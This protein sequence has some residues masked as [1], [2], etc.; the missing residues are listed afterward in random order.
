MQFSLQSATIFLLSAACSLAGSSP[1][2]VISEPRGELELAQALA[3][4][5]ARSPELE[6]YSWDVRIAEAAAMQAVAR[7][8]PELSFEVENALGGGAY[9]DFDS[10]EETLSLSQTIELGRK[11]MKRTAVARHEIAL[12]EHSFTLKRS[13]VLNG[14]TKAFLDVISAQQELAFAQTA[15]AMQNDLSEAQ[16]ALVEA[17]KIS[18]ADAESGKAALAFAEIA[19]TN[20]KAGLDLARSQLGAFWG[21]ATPHFTNAV[22][23]IATGTL[24]SR[25]SY[26]AGLADNPVLAYHAEAIRRH[27]AA[28][29]LEEAERTPD[30]TIGVGA[31]HFEDSDESAAVLSIS[32]PLPLFDRREGQI[33][34]AKA[35]VGKA[36]AERESASAALSAALASA[37]LRLS[38]AHREAGMLESSAVPAAKRSYDYAD[39][40]YRLGKFSYLELKTAQDALTSARTLQLRARI[41]FH[42]ARAD[43][44]TLAGRTH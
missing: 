41:R 6:P 20:A 26:E 31:R 11:R 8:N 36:E 10:A 37:Y 27:Q 13:E 21:N 5:L 15:E 18:P 1:P 29:V 35:E 3:L 17:G 4:T 7:L 34:K 32:I 44:E 16:G 38:A 14:A 2:G 33:A 12:G 24:P 22:G 19:V 28:V 9:R 43:L 23:S 39:E 42:K 40:G 30:I 25:S